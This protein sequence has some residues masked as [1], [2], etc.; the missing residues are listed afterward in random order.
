MTVGVLVCLLACLVLLF[1]F[2][3]KKLNKEANGE[4]TVRHIIY[5]EGGVRDQVRGAAMAVETRLGVQLW[6]RGDEEGEEMESV[7]AGQSVGGDSC[8]GEDTDGEDTDGE[9]GEDEDS[10]EYSHSR[11]EDEDDKSSLDGAE[12]GDQDRLLGEAEKNDETESKEE[13]QQAKE[14]ATGTGLQID[15]KQFS[16]SVIWSE[17]GGEGKSGDVT[18]L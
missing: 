5:K 17:E 10:E 16:G 13:E 12:P 8:R 14:E 18:A 11:R 7:E 4:Y 3:Y 6:P 9:D 2:L 15:L 1:L